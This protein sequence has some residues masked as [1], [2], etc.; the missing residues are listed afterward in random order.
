MCRD[1]VPRHLAPRTHLVF[2]LPP[3]TRSG[4]NSPGHSIGDESMR[5][6]VPSLSAFAV[7][8]GSRTTSD[9]RAQRSSRRMVLPALAAMCLACLA[10]S[11]AGGRTFVALC[12]SPAGR[13]RAG[14]L[15]ERLLNRSQSIPTGSIARDGHFYRGDQRV[16][17][18]GVNLCFGA[19]FPTPRG[20]RPGRD[21]HGRGGRQFRPAPSHGHLPL[22]GGHLER[23]GRPDHRAR[24]PRPAGLLHQR[25]GPS[26]ASSSTSTCTSATST[27]RS[28]TCRRRTANST[29][30]TGSSRRR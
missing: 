17:I 6:H 19:N 29:R 4:M 20:R 12:H 30:S 26:G 14:D 8:S 3:T 7:K 15:G 21:P 2:V 27:A 13:S 25:A 16:R 28:W 24:G 18:W 5:N 11:V 9:T 1:R 22:A 23:Q 10:G